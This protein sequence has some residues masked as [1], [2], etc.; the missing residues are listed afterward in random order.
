MPRPAS[1]RGWTLR[2]GAP[3]ATM[4][5]EENRTVRPRA[6]CR[7][8]ALLLLVLVCATAVP[9]LQAQ[10][11][12]A[13]PVLDLMSRMSPEARVGQLVLVTYP[14]T[15]VGADSEIAALVR[16]Y[17]IGGVLM[18][19]QNGNF[20][21]GIAPGDLVSATNALQQLAWDS[22]LAPA[23]PEAE[24]ENLEPNLPY[25]PLL[26]AVQATEDGV[27]PI[28]YVHGSSSTPTQMAIGATWDRETA[29]T[30]GAVL[31]RELSALGINLYLGPDLDVL[32]VPRPG[33]PADLG[34]RVFGGDPFWVG[35]MGISYIAGL[36]GGSDGRLL[37]APRHLPGLGSADRPLDDEIPTVQKPLE[38][39]RQIELVPFFAAAEQVEGRASTADAFVVTHIRYRGFQGNNIRQTTRPISLDA[40]ALQLVT[41]LEDVAPWRAD[42][43]VLIADNLG[44]Q[45]V[46]LSYDPRGQAFNARRVAQDALSA[47]NDLLMLD[48]FGSPDDWAVHFA[49]IRD[50]LQFLATRYR[51]EP[52]FQALVDAAVYRLLSMK[53]GV[54]PE[55]GDEVV[56]VDADLASETL[57]G[58]RSVNAQVASQALTLVFPLTDDLAPSAPQESESIVVFAQQ[59]SDAGEIASPEATVSGDTVAETMRRFYGPDGAGTLSPGAVRA[60]TYRD[61]L[62]GLEPPPTAETPEGV[63]PSTIVTDVNNALARADWIVFVTTGSRV[64]LDESEALQQF[65]TTRVGLVDAQI[66]VLSFGPPYELDATDI[67]KLDV[68]YELYSSGDAFVEA[69][70]RA[71]FRDVA[72]AGDSPVD[73]PALNYAISEQTMP[74]PEQLLTLAVVDEVGEVLTETAMTNIHVGDLIYLKTGVI[75]DRNGRVVPDGTPVDF[76]LNYPQESI[77]HRIVAETS[78]GLAAASVTLDRVGQLDITVRSEPAVSSVKLELMIRDD[79]VTITEVEPT[80]TPTPTATP[81]PTATPAPTATP[82]PVP[83]KIGHLPDPPVLPAPRRSHLLRWGLFGAGLTALSGFLLAREQ[84]RRSELAA[85]VALATLIG[86]LIAYDLVMAV[87]RWWVPGLHFLAVTRE[88]MTAVVSG[89][90]GILVMSFALRSARRKAEAARIRAASRRDGRR[91][92][93]DSL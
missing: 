40:T 72:A 4:V 77:Q 75:L 44:M 67:S 31:G 76:S 70:V 26:I 47:G 24:T 13:D 62:T 1:L 37:V 42:G 88:Y 79:G 54:Y 41:G 64:G 89:A 87:G 74:A 6:G 63:Q 58:G 15:D 39:L 28:S 91:Y 7:G 86:A 22:A 80:A 9:A 3:C 57:G 84:S 81:V 20:G 16:D 10:E 48:R 21:T 51:D 82:N 29:E 55:M 14:D 90:G 18:R 32:Y 52:G 46:L 11:E 93:R 38:M 17:H 60:F 61:L 45:S 8:I 66:A 71:L 92:L 68:F 33:D 49:N 43:G 5:A 30:V 53:S 36:H 69:G 2:R 65:L 35:Q 73:I 34:T 19:P 59:G 23:L 50:T 27:A 25:V 78:D 12:A 56:Q 83:L 85:Q